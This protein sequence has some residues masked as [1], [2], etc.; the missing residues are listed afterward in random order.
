MFKAKNNQLAANIQKMFMEREGTYNL[1]GLLN[2]KTLSVHTTRK[3]FCN[4]V[5]GVKLW[6]SLNEEL[7]KC[8]NMKLFKKRYE[9]MIFRRNNYDNL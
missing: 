6:K 5:C 4:S 9:E 3:S 8:P 1:R 7:K 2:F